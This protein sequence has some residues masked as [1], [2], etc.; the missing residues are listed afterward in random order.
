MDKIC[1]VRGY[2]FHLCS[3]YT[4]CETKRLTDYLRDILLIHQYFV[5]NT[6][7]RKKIIR[8]R[9]DAARQLRLTYYQDERAAGNEESQ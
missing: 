6:E 9:L 1:K 2:S 3:Y 4:P 7:E 5:L 8:L